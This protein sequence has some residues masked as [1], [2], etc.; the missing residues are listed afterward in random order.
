[1]M[2]FKLCWLV[3]HWRKWIHR[4]W[5]D[6][7]SKLWFSVYYGFSCVALNSARVLMKTGLYPESVRWVSYVCMGSGPAHQEGIA[8]IPAM[9][10]HAQ[11]PQNRRSCSR[12]CLNTHTQ[13]EH[14]KDAFAVRMMTL[15]LLGAN[16]LL[17]LKARQVFVP[18]RIQ[19]HDLLFEKR[20]TVGCRMLYMTRVIHIE[21]AEG[22][23]SSP[24]LLV[25]HCS[26]KMYSCGFDYPKTN[27]LF[28]KMT[29]NTHH[30]LD[31]L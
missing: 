23:W 28:K 26:A 3:W 21:S 1:M 12:F 2:T 14:T 9:M 20:V 10:S 4:K 8:H 11:K 6:C 22:H 25:I 5:S 7:W 29:L 17:V 13:G 27:V 18:F 19:S 30:L 16:L 24:P 31:L 15:P